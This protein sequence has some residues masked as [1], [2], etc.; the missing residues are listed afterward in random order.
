MDK[1]V[2]LRDLVMACGAQEQPIPRECL[3]NDKNA[4]MS[5]LERNSGDTWFNFLL[6][7][8]PC[9]MLSRSNK[10]SCCNLRAPR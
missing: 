2:I 10:I 1:L 6:R 5:R 4:E 8:E 7:M 3:E 9:I